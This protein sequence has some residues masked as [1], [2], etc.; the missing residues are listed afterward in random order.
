MTLSSSCCRT[1]RRTSPRF[2]CGAR[3]W[4]CGPSRHTGRLRALRRD[5]VPPSSATSVARGSSAPGQRSHTSCSPLASR[6]ARARVAPAHR[7]PGSP[8]ACAPRGGTG[9]NVATGRA[10][11]RGE[12]RLLADIR[13]FRRHGGDHERCFRARCGPHLGSTSCHPPGARRG[14]RGDRACRGSGHCCGRIRNEHGGRSRPCRRRPFRLRTPAS[15]SSSCRRLEAG[16]LAATSIRSGRHTRTGRT[17][18]RSRITSA[19]SRSHSRWVGSWVAFSATERSVG[20]A[21]RP[22]RAASSRRSLPGSSSRCRARSLCS[23]TTCGCRRA[24]SGRSCPRFAS[25]PAGTRC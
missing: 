11:R 6:S 22:P 12:P 13:L 3:W 18:P 15:S 7:S 14:C 5:D 16:S 17:R 19:C 10:R 20:E 2:W 4:L 23:V 1:T 21:A 9:A 25:S 24:F 8:D